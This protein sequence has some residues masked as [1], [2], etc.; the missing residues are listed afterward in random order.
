MIAPWEKK[1]WMIPVFFAFKA[2]TFW[3]KKLRKKWE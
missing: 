1:D 3:P 2:S